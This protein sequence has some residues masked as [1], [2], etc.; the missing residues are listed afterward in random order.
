MSA[1][2]EARGREVGG[3]NDDVVLMGSLVEE[4]IRGAID[5]LVRLDADAALSVIAG[6]HRINEMQRVIAAA[7][8]TAIATQ[9]PVAR[10]L[11]FLLSL[12]HVTYELERMRYHASSVAKQA[13]KLAPL[14]PLKRCVDPPQIGELAARPLHHLL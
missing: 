2:A 8:T 12:D 11:R 9:S 4:A 7:I 10:D 3:V 5:A 13:R 1:A 6:D 14:P